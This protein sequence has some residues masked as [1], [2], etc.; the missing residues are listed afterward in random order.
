MFHLRSLGPSL[1]P[2]A[3]IYQRSCKIKDN[4]TFAQEPKPQGE[5]FQWRKNTM[6]V[7]HKGV[8]L[9][10]ANVDVSE[11]SGFPQI[12]HFDRVFHYFHHPFWGTTI[13]GHTYVWISLWDVLL[14]ISL[15]NKVVLYIIGPTL[16]MVHV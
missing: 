12:I 7:T 4:A 1:Y 10:I 2:F 6:E 9:W 13:F 3:E 11:N 8:F 15:N 16:S 5:N 14:R